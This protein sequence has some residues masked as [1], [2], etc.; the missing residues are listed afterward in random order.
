MQVI[1]K[2]QVAILQLFVFIFNIKKAFKT[3]NT[4]LKYFNI[5]R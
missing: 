3:V 5:L 1:D 2:S 4:D